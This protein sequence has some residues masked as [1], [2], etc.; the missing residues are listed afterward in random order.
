VI[1]KGQ[2][3][4]VYNNIDK[5]KEKD[6]SQ[7]VMDLLKRSDEKS[8]GLVNLKEEQKVEDTTKYGNK[9]GSNWLEDEQVETPGEELQIGNTS[10]H[11]HVKRSR[12]P[13]TRE[14]MIFYGKPWEI[15]K[16]TSVT[17][18]YTKPKQQNPGAIII[19][20]CY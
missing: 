3:V 11:P 14:G 12:R 16:L 1:W 7:K 13:S 8:T 5:E 19:L 10:N 4:K 2:E 15:K 18:Q 6:S 9:V 20:A 17:L